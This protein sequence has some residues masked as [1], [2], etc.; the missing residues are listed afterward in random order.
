MDAPAQGLGL[1]RGRD[2]EHKG[3][4]LSTAAIDAQRFGGVAGST[5]TAHQAPIDVLGYIVDLEHT[6]IERLRLVPRLVGL[7]ETTERFE[8]PQEFAPQAITRRSV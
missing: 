7:P 5:V 3:E 4:H 6:L 1:R 8:G 2:P